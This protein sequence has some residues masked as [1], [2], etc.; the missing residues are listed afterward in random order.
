M[1][2]YGHDVAAAKVGARGLARWLVWSGVA[3]QALLF[4][5]FG[6]AITFELPPTAGTLLLK[7]A[8]LPSMISGLVALFAYFSISGER[9]ALAASGSALS[10]V[11]CI[12]GSCWWLFTFW[13]MAFSG[14]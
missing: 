14:A 12:L 10:M 13:L 3:C 8:W 2:P 1:R 5:V 4:G 11:A 7:Y 6:L 9:R